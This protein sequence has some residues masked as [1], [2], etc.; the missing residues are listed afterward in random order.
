MNI[1]FVLFG[2]LNIFEFHCKIYFF[3]V[4]NIIIFFIFNHEM[5]QEQCVLFRGMYVSIYLLLSKNDVHF[6]ITF[7]QFSFSFQIMKAA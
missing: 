2:F 5:F 4:K 6:E 3:F 7:K 1:S